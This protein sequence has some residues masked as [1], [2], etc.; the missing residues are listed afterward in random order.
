LNS[1]KKLPSRGSSL[2]NNIPTLPERTVSRALHQI[3]TAGV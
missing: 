1:S 3:D 2:P